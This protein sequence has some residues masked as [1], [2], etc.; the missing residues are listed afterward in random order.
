MA[1]AI[2]NLS[3]TWA[4]NSLAFTAISMNVANNGSNGKSRLLDLKVDGISKQYTT[5]NGDIFI[6]GYYQGDGSK[7]TG[8]AGGP[9]GTT[10]DTARLIANTAYD[11]ANSANILAFQVSGAVTT[12]NTIASAAYDKANSANLLAFSGGGSSAIASAAYDKANAANLLAFS[13][14]GGST[15]A[16]AAYDKANSANLLAF[17]RLAN[18]AGI[19]TAGA[20]NVPG[21]LTANGFTITPQTG[22]VEGAEFSMQGAGDFDDWTVDLY[23]DTFRMFTSSSNTNTFQVFNYGTANVNFTVDGVAG[24]GTAFPQ[25]GRAL[26]LNGPSNYYGLS[27]LVNDV[28]EGQIIQES[29]G[30]IYFDAGYT[31]NTGSMVFRT[32]TGKSRMVISKDGDIAIGS[33]STANA[34]ARYLDVYNAAPD[35]S[36]AAVLRLI[37]A[38]TTSSS[39]IALVDFVKYKS[40]P[41]YINNSETDPAALM[42][43]GLGGVQRMTI[44]SNGNIG[45]G[46]TTPA[47][48]LDIDGNVRLFSTK[49]LEL[50]LEADT[51]NADEQDYPRIVLKQ[52]GGTR[53]TNIGYAGNTSNDFEIETQDA[54]SLKLG[55]SGSPRLTIDA[56]GNVGINTTSPTAQLQIWGGSRTAINAYGDGGGL[57]IDFQ[58][59]STHYYQANLHR[60]TTGSPSYTEVMR[61][62]TSGNVGIGTTSPAT[63]FVISGYD[64]TIEPTSGGGRIIQLENSNTSTSSKTPITFY[65][66]DAGGT[67]RHGASILW[68]KSGPWTSGGNDY[69]SYLGFY[70]RA[71]GTTQLERVRIDATGNVGIGTATPAHKLQVQGGLAV[72]GNLA[73]SYTGFTP[74]SSGVF[75]GSVYSGVGAEYTAVEMSSN[76]GSIIDFTANGEDLRGRIIYVNASNSMQFSTATATRM[77][78]DGSGNVGIGTLSPLYSLDVAGTANVANINSNGKNLYG[79]ELLANAQSL[80]SGTS[81]TFSSI[82]SG[83]HELRLEY[84]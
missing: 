13:A 18:T 54:N 22:S 44:A 20:L 8:I 62:D 52:D 65:G 25:A 37:T 75:M 57:L 15:I 43:F 3:A 82:P 1:V 80:G 38:N 36:T 83:Y 53:V 41:F 66:A 47:Y 4:N 32:N 58:G 35:N 81:F 42:G 9:G 71:T 12:A 64:N 17:G 7:L 79:W 56:S 77:T 45:I 14:S 61:I 16:A 69:D 68:G 21:M 84:G 28:L 73:S 26:S 19:T 34:T 48:K 76:T 63:R 5:P 33:L 30:S 10:D 50:I 67:L 72:T 60:F 23:G 70:T 24:I 78:L 46:T 31:T 29:T 11:K 27:L 51:D 59:T 55:T 2:S 74:A 49:S 6:T 39:G 40:G